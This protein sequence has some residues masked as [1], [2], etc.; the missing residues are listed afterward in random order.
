M[1]EKMLV[2]VIRGLEM[3]VVSELRDDTGMVTYMLISK[4]AMLG[5]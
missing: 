3:V 4:R 5:A 2:V 1:E